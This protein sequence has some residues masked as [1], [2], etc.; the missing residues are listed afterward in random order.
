MARIVA[1]MM[2][3]WLL[4]GSGGVGWAQ[5]GPTPPAAVGEAALEG[6]E[7]PP[8]DG[9]RNPMA[10]FV[11]VAVVMIILAIIVALALKQHDQAQASAADQPETGEGPAGGPS[12]SAPPGEN[13]D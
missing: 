10:P 5:P 8:P 3:V 11:I 12:E 4:T 7:I 9:Q 2:V 1:F 13:C 6:L